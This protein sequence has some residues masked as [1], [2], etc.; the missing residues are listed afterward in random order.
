V[1]QTRQAYPTL[2]KSTLLR[3]DGKRCVRLRVKLSR[4]TPDALP[5][6]EGKTLAEIRQGK[7]CQDGAV[8]YSTAL[9]QQWLQTRGIAWGRR[10]HPADRR[11]RHH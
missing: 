1:L 5:T 8:H 9:W 11:L 10:W 2:A 4:P 3:K 6:K 7:S